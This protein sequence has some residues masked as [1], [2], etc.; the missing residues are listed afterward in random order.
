MPI[1]KAGVKMGEFDIIIG[2]AYLFLWVPSIVYY[3][4]LKQRDC[5]DHLLKSGDL[6]YRDMVRDAE[7]VNFCIPAI[8]GPLT[9]IFSFFRGRRGKRWSP[10]FATKKK[11]EQK[12]LEGWNQYFRAGDGDL[13]SIINSQGGYDNIPHFL[14]GEK[15]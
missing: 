4:G 10:V 13:E 14:T 1:E 9:F 7:V 12:K 8:L 5:L 15:N 11:F 6:V 3:H 2:W